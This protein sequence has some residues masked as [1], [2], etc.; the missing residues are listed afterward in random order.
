[1]T[2]STTVKEVPAEL[3]RIMHDAEHAELETTM[4]ETRFTIRARFLAGPSVAVVTTT[5]MG[6]A[7]WINFT[8]ITPERKFWGV[9]YEDQIQVFEDTELKEDEQA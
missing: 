7:N 9:A 3:L 8:V 4:H 6:L 2:T 5:I 1:V